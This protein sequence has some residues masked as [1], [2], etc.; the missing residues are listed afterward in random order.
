MVNHVFPPIRYV[1]YHFSVRRWSVCL[2]TTRRLSLCIIGCNLL[3]YGPRCNDEFKAVLNSPMS[4]CRVVETSLRTT[5]PY[6]LHATQKNTST[7]LTAPGWSL[8]LLALESSSTSPYF[9]F[10][11]HTTSSLFGTESVMHGWHFHMW[12]QSFPVLLHSPFPKN[13]L[14]T[15]LF[16]ILIANQPGNWMTACLSQWIQVNFPPTIWFNCFSRVILCR[17]YLDWSWAFLSD[18]KEW[19]TIFLPCICFFFGPSGWMFLSGLPLSQDVD[20]HV[21]QFQ[22]ATS[23]SLPTEL[24]SQGNGPRNGNLAGVQS[25]S[26]PQP[27]ICRAACNLPCPLWQPKT[28]GF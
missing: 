17:F 11:A 16:V 3:C 2:F 14:K 18:K 21:P 28:D 12:D 10:T 5:G 19:K 15:S 9:M 25:G 26:S 27:A 8:W 7:Q 1:L 20:Y 23:V 6:S 4:Q 24:L 13:S 22:L